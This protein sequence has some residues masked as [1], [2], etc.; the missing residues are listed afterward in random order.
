MGMEHLFT[1]F[2][3]LLFIATIIF[4]CFNLVSVVKMLTAFTIGHA[5][6]LIMTSLGW[7]HVP[8]HIAD[9]GVAATII[10]VAVQNMLSR[11]EVKHRWLIIFAFG[12]IHGMGFAHSLGELLPK[13]GL[14]LCLL[15]FNIGIELAQIMIAAVMFPV[16]A[17]IQWQKMM[18]SGERGAKEFRTL[19]NLRLWI[20]SHNGRILALY[21]AIWN[22][23]AQVT[24]LPADSSLPRFHP[25][26]P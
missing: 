23:I 12:L 13:E 10:I 8:G 1:G 16:L 5:L 11:E 18:L 20:Y 14:I 4:A 7:F 9:I 15:S 19:L 22:R 17:R 25:P 6:T 3:H 26:L 24:P 2:D 21:K